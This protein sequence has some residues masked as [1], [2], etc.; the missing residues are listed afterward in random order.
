MINCAQ[1]NK[2]WDMKVDGQPYAQQSWE[3]VSPQS[4]INCSPECREFA[5]LV[6]A[7]ALFHVGNWIVP[8]S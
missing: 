1:L 2:R 3:A 6:L 5:S 7:S 4:L 8:W